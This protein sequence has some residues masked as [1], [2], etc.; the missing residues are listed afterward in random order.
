M[1]LKKPDIALILILLAALIL[2]TYN[3]WQ[4]DAANQYYLAAV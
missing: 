4:D 2:N 3:I 1:K